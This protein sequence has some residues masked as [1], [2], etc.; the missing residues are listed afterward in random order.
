MASEIKIYGQK[1][2]LSKELENYVNVRK[3]FQ[4]LS[5]KYGKL[6]EKE[7]LTDCH[8]V[9]AIVNK[10][11]K[12]ADNYFNKAGDVILDRLATND[13]YTVRSQDILDIVEECG[14]LD[15]FEKGFSAIEKV[16]Y[17]IIQKAE[18]AKRQRELRKESRAR[19]VGGGFGI[20]GAIRGIIKA[21]LLNQVTGLGHSA[22]NAF[23]NA[24]TERE[25]QEQLDNLHFIAIT[26]LSGAFKESIANYYIAML[27][28]LNK[29]EII[30]FEWPSKKDEEQAK[31][32]LENLEAGR[33]P[34]EKINS[35]LYNLVTLD[36][37]NM[38]MYSYVLKNQGDSKNELEKF[39]EM[40]GINIHSM[41]DSIIN[42][43]FL[44]DINEL[45]EVY[46][47]EKEP[48]QFEKQLFSIQSKIDKK[49][50]FLGLTGILQCE[51]LIEK[52]LN[53][54]NIRFKT[55]DGVIF[56]SIEEAK[57]AK[58]D[59][60]K[61][62][63]YIS[64]HGIESEA[65]RE[66][67]NKLEFKTNIVTV[68][69]DKRL[70]G[71]K[72]LNDD[73]ELGKR[74]N[75]ILIRK[76]FTTASTR[77][78]YSFAKK[79]F[80]IGVSKEFKENAQRAKK[81]AK[82]DATEKIVLIFKNRKRYE[83]D[84]TWWVL[85]TNNL[86]TFDNDDDDINDIKVVSYLDIEFIHADNK[87]NLITRI[88]GGVDRVCKLELDKKCEQDAVREKLSNA[89][90]EIYYLLAPFTKGREISE[91]SKKERKK[92]IAKLE[93][94]KLNKNT[95]WQQGLMR[96]KELKSHAC[97]NDNSTDFKTLLN[98]ANQYWNCDF[99][100]EI[101]YF[102]MV[103]S[104]IGSSIVLTSE[105][106][107]IY[108]KVYST[109][110]KYVFPIDRISTFS[111][112]G[113]K[114]EYNMFFDVDYFKENYFDCSDDGVCF[115]TVKFHMF[116]I[117][118]DAGE[119]VCATLTSL[120]EEIRKP[121]IEKKKKT[122]YYKKA[123]EQADNESK[124]EQLVNEIKK[125]TILD[126]NDKEMFLKKAQLRLEKYQNTA[127][128]KQALTKLLSAI[129]KDDLRTINSTLNQILSNE[130][131]DENDKTAISKLIDMQLEIGN[132]LYEKVLTSFF[133]EK[134][135]VSALLLDKPIYMK[136]R[137][138]DVAKEMCEFFIST[139][140]EVED[141]EV[142]LL[143]FKN[144][145]QYRSVGSAIPDAEKCLITNKR[146]VVL[147]RM[148]NYE[149]HTLDDVKIK[150]ADMMHGQFV[151]DKNDKPIP[152]C[153]PYVKVEQITDKEYKNQ[154]QRK[155][156]DADYVIVAK[157]L[158][159]FISGIRR[160]SIEIEK[161]KAVLEKL[162]TDNSMLK[163]LSKGELEKEYTDWERY[164]K[165]GSKVTDY[166]D[167]IRKI[168]KDIYEKEA[169]EMC[170]GLSEMSLDELKELKEKLDEVFSN[171]NF[172]H[173]IDGNKAV[174][175]EE[176]QKRQDIAIREEIA[177]N[178]EKLGDFTRIELENEYDKWA[179]Y[180]GNV[181]EVNEY[182]QMLI[183]S[184]EIAY[185]KEAQKMCVN[186]EQLTVEEAE[187]LLSSF[188]KVFTRKQYVHFV[189]GEKQIVQ[190]EIQ[191][192]RICS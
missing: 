153:F 133:K 171:K 25:K 21:E 45:C 151:R 43:L 163:S 46:K 176:I 166:L 174:V 38:N 134:S 27:I 98:K 60:N 77:D 180:T 101:I 181:K 111:P 96:C 155:L 35:A 161:M 52:E 30:S 127:T 75:N 99:D 125:D 130:L 13:I 131:F 61:F 168:I 15:P 136:N 28:V 185:K 144:G 32:I 40:H 23:G 47:K 117:P 182:R 190:V 9:E 165:Y 109:E 73:K 159:D 56:K 3:E 105:R 39:G 132:K 20:D 76:G 18:E 93:V 146:L 12:L 115:N 54:L 104:S 108:G 120:E 91:N 170:T 74:I 179:S 67:I 172:A 86:Y 152:F 100:D 1:Y 26:M 33:I 189:E 156:N 107:Y 68:N 37:F 177:E 29:Y 140:L 64:I 22:F 51:K 34:K 41:K 122:E 183:K 103:D 102:V 164:E 173:F 123:I 142:P 53:K 118:E 145:S 48:V 138:K 114:K 143:L 88:R 42:D 112:A 62:Y 128:N 80:I 150:A 79:V 11:Y 121:M 70:E 191:K 178:S 184:I 57:L 124:A 6:Y 8:N 63:E 110:Q 116:N 154:L 129:K 72:L 58:K 84:F 186:L 126:I 90:E 16:Y 7:L 69:L 92:D 139:R 14:I 55:V 162:P 148:D 85:S 50:K 119:S 147:M 82:I 192:K 158:N 137:G 141:D 17:N 49:K 89:M 188:D 113:K 24:R 87:G 106:C 4:N 65:I 94:K 78:D 83:G 2:Q 10:A 157:E 160:T 19:F 31:A 81:L 97:I 44:N 187:S 5:E 169:S 66:E 175:K 71:M 36:P 167:S 95:Y 135:V 149:I 59:L